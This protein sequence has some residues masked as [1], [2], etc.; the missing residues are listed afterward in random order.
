MDKHI[1][2]PQNLYHNNLGIN[3]YRKLKC[4]KNQVLNCKE[5]GFNK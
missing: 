3:V 4:D 1:F 2:L 5:Q